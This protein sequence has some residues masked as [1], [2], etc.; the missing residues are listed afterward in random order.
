MKRVARRSSS[1][2]GEDAPVS[3]EVEAHLL[4]LKNIKVSYT[5]KNHYIKTIEC[6]MPLVQ[7][8]HE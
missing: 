8:L 1:L 3:N 5:S 2:A 4:V 6:S 7:T